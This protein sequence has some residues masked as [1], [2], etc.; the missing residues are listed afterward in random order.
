M[1]RGDLNG[2][3]GRVFPPCRSGSSED[4]PYSVQK[5]RGDDRGE[6][7]E[8]RC[9]QVIQHDA[10]LPWRPWTERPRRATS[11]ALALPWGS[12]GGLFERR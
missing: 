7:D 8:D 3:R 1:R 10:G 5:A 9:N 4:I 11:G 2:V 12:G 6:C